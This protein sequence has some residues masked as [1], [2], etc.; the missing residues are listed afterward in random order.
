MDEVILLPD[1]LGCPNNVPAEISGALAYVGCLRPLLPFCDF[2]L[3][4]ITL[5]QAFVT[6]ECDGAV[7]NKNV[8]TI[9]TPDESVALGVIE[10]LDRAFHFPEPPSSA[11]PLERE[12]PTGMTRIRMQG[13]GI[14]MESE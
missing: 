4:L 10:P 1:S 13:G 2:E 9:C 12:N 14:R 5:L 7:V 6:L 8:G 3:N 11:R